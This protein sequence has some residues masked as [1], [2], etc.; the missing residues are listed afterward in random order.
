MFPS[1][2]SKSFKIPFCLVLF[3]AVAQFVVA[4]RLTLELDAGL[5]LSQLEIVDR[6]IFQVSGLEFDGKI[7]CNIIDNLGLKAGV[8]QSL[9]HRIVVEESES[10]Q[11]S[12]GFLTTEFPILVDVQCWKSKR[13]FPRFTLMAGVSLGTMWYSIDGKYKRGN[14]NLVVDYKPQVFGLNNYVVGGL[15]RF[16]KHLG[17][18]VEAKMIMK[19]LKENFHLA[20]SSVK[21]VAIKFS[22]TI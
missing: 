10:I 5:N 17:V 20:P 22:Y 1:I 9:N 14:S 15:F 11:E 7:R 12:V 8:T 21:S 6:G 18:S 2:F 13:N 4:Q 3:F 19:R 16:T